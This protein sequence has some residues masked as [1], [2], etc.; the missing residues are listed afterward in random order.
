MKMSTNSLISKAAGTS[1]AGRVQAIKHT[2]PDFIPQRAE[3]KPSVKQA[4][5]NPDIPPPKGIGDFINSPEQ[6]R[7]AEMDFLA[8]LQSNQLFPRENAQEKAAVKPDPEEGSESNEQNPSRFDTKPEREATEN[9]DPSLKELSEEEQKEVQE[10]KARDTE[11]FTHENAHIAAAGQYAK[12][13]AQYEYSTGPDGSRYR[14]GGKVQ[15]D[16]GEENSPEKTIEK[17][18][19]IKRAAFAPAEP[20]PED[21]AVAAE[22]D[23][24]AAKARSEQMKEKAGENTENRSKA[25]ETETTANKNQA[26]SQANTENS[27]TEETPESS[28]AAPKISQLKMQSARMAYIAQASL[29][30]SLSMPS[31]NLRG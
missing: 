15:I 2:D 11:V 25:P 27:R 14:T 1:S 29:Q 20:S 13:G 23:R 16:T 21:R 31:L 3:E 30:S 8:L 12:G 28:A 19:T 18:Q 5:S 6:N 9:Y 17:A 7:N 10:L 24:M 22:A 4:A 26:E